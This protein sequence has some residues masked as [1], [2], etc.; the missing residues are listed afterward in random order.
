MDRRRCSAALLEC[1]SKLTKALVLQPEA[2]YGRL[3]DTEVVRHQR[4]T[5]RRLM[6]ADRTTLAKAPAAQPPVCWANAD[7]GS[8]GAH[9]DSIR[10]PQRHSV[11]HAAARDG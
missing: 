11:A 1:V 7:P 2:W 3:T 5:R 6:E 9:R 8:G 4:T 10:A